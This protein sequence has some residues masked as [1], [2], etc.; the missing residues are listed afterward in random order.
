MSVGSAMSASESLV[1]MSRISR[2]GMKPNMCAA[3]RAV[4]AGKSG[5][6]HGCVCG[7]VF[8]CAQPGAATRDG[9]SAPDLH[10][11]PPSA[12]TRLTHGD[13]QDGRKHA[14]NHKRH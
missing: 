12:G 2:S 10:A 11:P 13:G 4:R 8:R 6:M 5:A 3:G 14:Q 9:S 1:C 7:R